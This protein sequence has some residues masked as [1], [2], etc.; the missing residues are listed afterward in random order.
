MTSWQ[1]AGNSYGEGSKCHPQLVDTSRCCR[2]SGRAP[3]PNNPVQFAGRN[4]WRVTVEYLVNGD[5]LPEEQ[6]C[7]S[8]QRFADRADQR[9]QLE[10]GVVSLAVDEER[11]RSVYAAAHAAGKILLHPLGE[12]ASLERSC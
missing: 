1:R 5:S 12:F 2:R 11:R 3:V 8:H 10:V 4:G 6:H 7:S 9:V